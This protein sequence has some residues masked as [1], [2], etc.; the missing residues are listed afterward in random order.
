MQSKYFK[1]SLIEKSYINNSK[2]FRKRPTIEEVQNNRWL[3][4]DLVRKREAITFTGALLNAFSLE[5]HSNKEK[6]GS[7]S[8]L[9]K[10]CGV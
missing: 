1:F 7:L 2:N 6:S 9:E 4:C 10:I 8:D 3:Y 5:F